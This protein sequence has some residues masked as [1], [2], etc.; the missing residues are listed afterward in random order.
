MPK[1]LASGTQD[2]D[3]TASEYSPAEQFAHVSVTISTE[4]CHW[5]YCVQKCDSAFEFVI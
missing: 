2:I 4:S 1:R 5:L 3:M